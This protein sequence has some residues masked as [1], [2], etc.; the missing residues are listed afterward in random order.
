MRLKNKT[1]IVLTAANT[2]NLNEKGCKKKYRN[3]YKSSSSS[4]CSSSSSSSSSSSCSSSSGSSSASFENLDVCYGKIKNL[5]GIN[6]TYTNALFSTCNILNRVSPLL[7]TA[8]HTVSVPSTYS[9]FTTTFLLNN[10]NISITFPSLINSNLNGAVITIANVSNSTINY[11]LSVF[12]PDV[13][14]VT[15]S[16]VANP[17]GASIAA[18]NNHQYVISY[19]NFLT[20]FYRIQ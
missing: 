1:N 14:N 3:C 9:N 10:N 12:S 13:I 7:L 11:G 8:N 6:I 15:G 20:T 5:T 19:N 17:Y 18:N 4:S 2:S 16:N